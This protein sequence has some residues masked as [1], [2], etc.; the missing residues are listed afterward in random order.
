MTPAPVNATADRV[1][2]RATG[3]GVGLLAFMIAWLIGARVTEQIWGPPS[4]AVVALAIS[5]MVGI[6]VAVVAGHRLL[7]RQF[8]E[9]HLAPDPSPRTAIQQR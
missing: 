3:V 9:S 6:L 1:A 7:H 5:V 4:S 2:A 8:A